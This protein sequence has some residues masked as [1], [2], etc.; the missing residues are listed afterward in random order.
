VHPNTVRLYEQWGFIPPAERSPSGYRLFTQRHLDCM[1]LARTALHAPYP[2]GKA[3]ALGLVRLAVAGD[4]RGA[5][6]LAHV[7]LA[8]VR[9]E[10]LRAEAAAA[11]VERWAEPGQAVSEGPGL[12]ISEAARALGVTA[13]ALRNW[14]RNGLIAVPR[15]SGSCY[16][17]YGPPEMERLQVI[18]ML[19]KA[20][21]GMAAI[22]RMM[23]YLD[24]GGCG[25]IL[26]RAS[27]VEILDTPPPD[28][29]IRYATD[30]WLSTLAAQ[31][32]RA[33]EAVA[34]LE[35]LQPSIGPPG[36]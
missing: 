12:R 5:L 30:N 10:R 2:G 27:A 15:Q 7:Y 22:L 8:Q 11:L 35:T 14:E 16:R 33:S 32:Q 31:E 26:G 24:E 36:L 28:E 9:R 1:R 20:G 19:A 6:E 17:L 25:D 18:R 34:Q 13:D 3:P 4:L 29:D 23:L 21:Y